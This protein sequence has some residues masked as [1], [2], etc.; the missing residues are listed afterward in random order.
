[1]PFIYV[2]VNGEASIDVSA[3]VKIGLSDNPKLRLRELQVSSPVRMT[4]FG[5][6]QVRDRTLAEYI[7]KIVHRTLRTNRLRGEWFYLP[8]NEALDIVAFTVKD[9]KAKSVPMANRTPKPKRQVW[10]L[11]TDTETL[12]EALASRAHPAT[13][14]VCECGH[15]A[16]LRLSKAEILRKRFRCSCCNR[17]IEGRRFFIRRVA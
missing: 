9:A 14:V 3:H 12:D 4:L 10:D 15:R 11:L 16:V 17:S 7:E 8:P 2:I 5:K 1:M 13:Q 6:I